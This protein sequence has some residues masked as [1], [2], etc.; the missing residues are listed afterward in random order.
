[1]RRGARA[2]RNG[3]GVRFSEAPVTRQSGFEGCAEG[4]VLG[5]PAQSTAAAWRCG[6][7]DW[8]DMEGA[9]HGDLDAGDQLGDGRG[10]FDQAD[11]DRVELRLV[12]E[13][14]VRCQVAQRQHEPSASRRRGGSQ[15]PELAGGGLAARGAV[16]GEVQLVG[17]D[18]R[19]GRARYRPSCIASW[20]SP[21]SSNRR[22]GGRRTRG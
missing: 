2:L 13:G 6:Q 9:R 10:D 3:L 16:G 18:F 20:A 17:S 15:K 1:M 4:F 12:P 21:C 7:R 11:P 22:S 14:V 5:H 8:P 19:P